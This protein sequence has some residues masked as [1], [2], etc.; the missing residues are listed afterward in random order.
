[1]PSNVISINGVDYEGKTGRSSFVNLVHSTVDML[2]DELGLPDLSTKAGYLHLIVG[3]GTGKSCGG[4]K[5]IR[6]RHT[7]FMSMQLGRQFR[8]MQQAQE[9]WV[10]SWLASHKGPSHGWWRMAALVRG[11]GPRYNEY[12]SLDKDPVIGGRFVKSADEAI[13]LLTAHEFAHVIQYA[14]LRRFDGHGPGFQQ[15]Y[16]KCREVLNPLLSE[17]PSAAE[18]AAVIK[19]IHRRAKAG[20]FRQLL[21]ASPGT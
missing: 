16:R 2:A 15:A 7:P 20:E 9:P 10:S 11:I 12:R 1:M 5:T 17:Q 19:D 21:A 3:T 8:I 14:S 18:Q 4:L 6:G 13:Q